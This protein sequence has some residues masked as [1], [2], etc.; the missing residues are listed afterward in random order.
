MGGE[1]LGK[2]F[3]GSFVRIIRGSEEFGGEVSQ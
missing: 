1:Q 2:W 3:T